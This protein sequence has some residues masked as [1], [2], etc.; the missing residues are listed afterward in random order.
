MAV[1][2]HTVAGQGQ[3][4]SP[5]AGSGEGQAAGDCGE[6]A[7]AYV[8]DKEQRGSSEPESQSDGAGEGEQD[9]AD[10]AAE[11]LRPGRMGPAREGRALSFT[12][13]GRH[14]EA[15]SQGQGYPY[16]RH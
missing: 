15:F 14:R 2:P 6:V 3:G 10:E 13:G 1:P 7:N 9:E 12:C 8:G 11:A 4:A 16:G 5:G